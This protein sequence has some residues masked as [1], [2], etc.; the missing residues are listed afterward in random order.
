MLFR[1]QTRQRDDLFNDLKKLAKDGGDRH[2]F[3]ATIVCHRT[4][5][6]KDVGAAQYRIFDIVDGQQRLTT[7]ILLLKCIE[8]AL[9]IDSE[10]RRDLAK[11]LVKRDGHLI[12]L[13]TN[14]ANE[15][16][17]NRFIRDGA[18]PASTDIATHSDRNLAN[19]IRDCQQFVS[20]WGAS[21]DILALMRIVLHRLGF[22]VFDTEDS[23][24]VYTVFEVLNSRGLAVDWL[25]KTKSTLMGRAFELASSPAAAQAEIQT[26][27]SAWGRIY[28]EIAK[29]DVPGDE[30]LRI[31]ATLYHGPGQG[32]PRSAEDSLD[33]IRSAADAFD[34]PRH[35]S[36]Q[37]LDVAT[38]LV[39]LYG[40]AHLGP[41]TEILH[42]R[43]LAVAIKSASG[44][45]DPERVK[46]LEQWERTTFR[47]FGLFGK[48]SRTKVGDY[49]RL[50]ARIV[51]N[52]IDM[53]TYNQILAGIRDL[54]AEYKIDKAIEEGLR[55]RDFYA[56]I[57]EC[58]YMLWSYEEYLAQIDGAQV[59]EQLRALI[60]AR[61]PANSI[62]HI[63]PQFPQGTTWLAKLSGHPIEP[64]V[65]R[66][67]NLLLLPADQNSQASRQPFDQKKA[68]YASYNSRMARDVCNVRDWTIANVEERE[69]KIIEWAKCRWGDV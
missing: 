63:I 26:L 2:H 58:R 5:E 36:S 17:F 4:T 66:I 10:D 35:I 43:L 54:G 46:L 18:R 8:L 29:E 45:S 62:E 65:H 56:R 44:V 37:L 13:Q 69:R 67:G 32:K 68:I 20:R 52:D 34:K 12:L 47:I 49:V 6:T 57:D 48:D 39:D 22:V 61:R 1:S 31:T 16:N 60:W 24:V 42:A 53:R 11:T 33:L 50:A 59:D 30:I 41:V 21:Q 19:A 25:D 40:S 15:L 3:M 51:A 27:Q 9:P 64:N 28:R 7:L 14:N 55:G 38:K 23:Q